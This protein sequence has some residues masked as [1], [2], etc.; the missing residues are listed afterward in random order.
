MTC[1]HD[2][3]DTPAR[4]RGLCRKHYNRLWYKANPR[5]KKGAKK[6]TCMHLD[7]RRSA[8]VR[9]T[10]PHPIQRQ[11]IACRDHAEHLPGSF[12]PGITVEDI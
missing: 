2:E 9:F 3:C 5:P 12:I 11:E 8:E 7:C 6:P 1:A 10:L 4:A